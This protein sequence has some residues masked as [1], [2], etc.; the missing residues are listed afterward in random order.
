MPNIRKG[1]RRPN[2]FF[3]NN[4]KGSKMSTN[5][6]RSGFL[7]LPQVLELIPVSRSSWWEGVRKGIY[8]KQVALGA[9][10]VGWTRES[11]DILI[12]SMCQEKCGEAR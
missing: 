11:I 5:I 4:Q 1:E 9:R 8:P 3:N 12:K 2:K 7:R 6:T 10:S